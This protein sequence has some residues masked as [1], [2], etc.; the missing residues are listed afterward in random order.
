MW[1]WKERQTNGRR[2][3]CRGHLKHDAMFSRQQRVG[4]AAEIP[5]SRKV[6]VQHALFLFFFLF[7]SFLFSFFLSSIGPAVWNSYSTLFF[8]F[9]LFFNFLNLFRWTLSLEQSPFL[10]ATCSKC[11]FLQVSER[12]RHFSNWC[13][14]YKVSNVVQGNRSDNHCNHFHFQNPA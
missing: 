5:W 3:S 12:A 2:Q 8:F 6:W 7:F 4:A 13:D 9:F 1:W 14:V 11:V 10:C